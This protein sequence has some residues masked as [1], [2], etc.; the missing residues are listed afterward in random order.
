MTHVEHHDGY[1]SAVPVEP[2]LGLGT[3]SRPAADCSGRHSADVERG[4]RAT[5]RYS[6]ANTIER[7]VMDHAL[8][9]QLTEALAAS[10]RGATTKPVS[11][12]LPTPLADAYRLLADRGLID[13]VSLATTGALEEALQAIIVG[14]RLD[15][16]YEE[17]PEARPTEEE[18]DAMAERA[19]L[20]ET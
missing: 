1:A 6:M 11:V 3:T 4:Q 2:R 17:H 13:S 10:R 9:D 14:M 15:V 8:L 12:T 20:H 16:I 19:G 7:L 18:I 5:I